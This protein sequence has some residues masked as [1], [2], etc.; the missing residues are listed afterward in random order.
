ML[1]V[2][3]ELALWR[4]DNMFLFTNKSDVDFGIALVLPIKYTLFNNWSALLL[5][6]AST[7]ILSVLLHMYTWAPLNDIFRDSVQMAM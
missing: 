4:Y 3:T 6:T 2:T 7:Y 5:C 1:L